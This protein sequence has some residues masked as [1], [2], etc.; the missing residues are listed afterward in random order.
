MFCTHYLHAHICSFCNHIKLLNFHLQGV[1]FII[2]PVHEQVALMSSGYREMRLLL[3][4][5]EQFAMPLHL[6]RSTILHIWLLVQA[7]EN[8]VES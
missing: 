7:N 3:Y 5:H 2:L 8:V 4:F 1:T 6:L